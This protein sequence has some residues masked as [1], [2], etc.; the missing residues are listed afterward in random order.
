[1][2][3]KLKEAGWSEQRGERGRAPRVDILQRRR[4]EAMRTRERKTL[5]QKPSEES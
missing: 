3:E 4:K 2:W 1:M 5:R